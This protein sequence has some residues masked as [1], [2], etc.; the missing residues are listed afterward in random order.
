MTDNPKRS[1]EKSRITWDEV[2]RLTE[3]ATSRW[4]IGRPLTAEETA[5]LE[6][7]LCDILDRYLDKS[8]LESVNLDDMTLDEWPCRSSLE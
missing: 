1:E 6:K 4:D 7:E 2:I 8:D 3:E 5:Q